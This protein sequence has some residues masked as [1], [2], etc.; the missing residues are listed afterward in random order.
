MKDNNY[1]NLKAYHIICSIIILLSI[2]TIGCNHT[3]QSTKIERFLIAYKDSSFLEFRNW[4][5]YPG[6]NKDTWI[7]DHY[8]ND[9]F[10][11]RYKV[12]EIDDQVYF[13]EILPDF[14]TVFLLAND[15]SQTNSK[16]LSFELYNSFKLL[17]VN[18]LFYNNRTNSIV[19]KLDDNNS[20]L[21]LLDGANFNQN[22]YKSYTKIDSVWYY[23]QH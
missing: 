15:I 16:E 5:I 21:R 19:I 14:D 22:V 20:I 12:M 11:I 23:Y 18:E 7:F 6:R 1:S 8:S 10:M 9:S 4:Q 3:T 13:K 2:C 17:G